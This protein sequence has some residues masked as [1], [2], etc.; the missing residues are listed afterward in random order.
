MIARQIHLDGCGIDE[1]NSY[2]SVGELRIAGQSVSSK[3]GEGGP[4]RCLEKSHELAQVGVNTL[5]IKLEAFAL[6]SRV[7]EVAQS[8]QEK[9]HRAK[10]DTLNR[11]LAGIAL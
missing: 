6:V 10:K 11:V 5:G 4:G 1:P 3:V 7:S 9:Q 8:L 2:W